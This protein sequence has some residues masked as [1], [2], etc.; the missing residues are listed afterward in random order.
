M[1]RGN[2]ERRRRKRIVG[3]KRIR[4]HKETTLKTF[5]KKRRKSFTVRLSQ[6]MV[7]YR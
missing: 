5:M 7:G 1:K 2:R 4:S 3:R 6:I